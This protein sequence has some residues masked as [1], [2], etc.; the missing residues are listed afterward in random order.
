MYRII[1]LGTAGGNEAVLKQMRSS[2]GILLN[3]GSYQAH[4][5]PGPGALSKLVEFGINPR[6]TNIILTSHNHLEHCNDIN[7]LIDS[8]TYAGL[9]NRESYI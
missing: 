8:M 5:D 9:D 2:G 1:F 4:L 3:L 7:A 6:D